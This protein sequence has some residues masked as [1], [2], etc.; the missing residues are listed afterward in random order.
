MYSFISHSET[1]SFTVSLDSGEQTYYAVCRNPMM[2]IELDSF[3]IYKPVVGGIIG[4]D[5]Y[6]SHIQ[7][8][9]NPLSGRIS[10]YADG[11][12]VCVYKDGNLIGGYDSDEYTFIAE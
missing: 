8:T 6:C 9:P 4:N 10:A 7:K 3:I 2:S 11:N 1:T 12:K 5:I